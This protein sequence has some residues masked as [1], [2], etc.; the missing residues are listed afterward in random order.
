[1]DEA[2]N[3]SDAK[4]YVRTHVNIKHG[5]NLQI[6]ASP[7]S[8]IDRKKSVTSA[9]L[10][11]G[12][13]NAVKFDVLIGEG[14]RVKAGE[15]VLRNRHRPEIVFT[16]PLSGNV[17]AVTRGTRR[18]LQSVRVTAD[19][20]GESV[21]ID[22]PSAPGMRDVRD[23][24][25]QSGLWTTLRARP[26]GRIPDPD[27]EPKALLITAIDTSPLAP[28]PAFIIAEYADKFALGLDAIRKI[29][30][31]PLYVCQRP[32]LDVPVY[33]S[34]Q[35]R[36]AEFEGPHPAGLPGTHI[37]SLCAIGFERAEVW[38]IGYQDVISVG[39]LMETGRPWFNRVVSLAGP[40]VL[41]PRL[42]SVPLGACIDD[43]VAS[44]LRGGS[45][46]VISG[47]VLSG[48]TAFGAVAYL[49]QRHHQITALPEASGAKRSWWEQ[50][51]LDTGL[52]GEPGP[53]IPT[54]DYEAVA[55]PGVLPVPLLRALL[56]GDT[57]R[58]RELG[59]L[60]LVEEDLSLLSFICPSKTDYGPLLRHVLD[61]LQKEVR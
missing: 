32:G 29:T 59:A 40:A 33:A 25:L 17:T 42:M 2:P 3:T 22:I 19:H 1:V 9:A 18:A 11:G 48:H 20:E 41:N 27:G 50:S 46:R 28:D 12:D 30:D 47:S 36:I 24:M 51:V 15:P 21:K 43:L 60:E 7:V 37:Q 38:H 5:M 55:P 23:L 10:L 26:F 6:G 58:A 44:E 8:V 45:V 39:H 35:V 52:G 13:F 14:A 49:G 16:A 57:E 31:A 53:L 4:S 54:G 61:E 56:V 34:E